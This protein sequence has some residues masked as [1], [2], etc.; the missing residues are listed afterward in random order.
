MGASSSSESASTRTRFVSKLY[1]YSIA[2]P[3]TPAQWD[4]NSAQSA[5]SSGPIEP[6]WASFDTYTQTATERAY[7]IGSRQLLAASKT[8]TRW[9]SFVISKRPSHC[10]GAPVRHIAKSMLS[11][12]A[13][14][15]F[16]FSCND[17]YRVV[18]V[19]ALHG[20]NGY[21][22]FFASPT[23]FSLTSD[24]RAFTAARRSFRFLSA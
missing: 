18:A 5:W 6:G 14:R 2:L 24:R 20:G 9:T 15:L 11:G 10:R 17:G 8:L 7:V 3:G 4:V 19:T 1:A 23:S 22:V 13:A 16:T 12:A 21:F